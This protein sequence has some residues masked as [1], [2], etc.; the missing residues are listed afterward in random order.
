MT[1]P[2]RVLAAGAAAP[3]LRLPA[4]EVSGAWGGGGK[5]QS[6]V[7]GPDEDALTLAWTAATSAIANAGLEPSKVG[8]L[9]WGTTRPPFA[10]GPSLALLQ[11]ALRLP[12]TAAGALLT[13]SPAAGMD[14]LLA[15]WD[16]VAAGSVDTA[17]VVV[18]DAIVPGL[19]TP[20]ER[21]A[22]AGAVALV[23]ARDGGTA[24]LTDRVLRTWPVLDRYRG[25]GEAETRDLY[26]PRLFR[27]EV[28]LPL[29][30][31]VG[32]AV[33]DDVRAWSL[34]D[35]DGRL[36]AAVARKL[37]ADASSSAAAYADLGDTGAAAALLGLLGALD[38]PGRVAVV[39]FG[40]GR[41]VAVTL[42]ADG[43]VP[44][45]GPRAL[46]DLGT[47]RL[48]SY[49]EVLRARG[50]LVPSG[51][52]VPMGVPPGG[53][54][55]VRGNVELLGLHGAQCSECGTVNVP[56][57]VHPTCINCGNAKFEVAELPST[58]TVHTFV[59]NHTMPAPF[60]APLPLVVVD[61][62][63]G[64]RIQLQGMPED[65]ATLAIG[66]RVDLHL[67]RYAVERGVPVYGFK[68]RRLGKGAS[69]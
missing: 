26:D 33:G 65:A 58:G 18:A 61:L 39:G 2:V 60:V 5:G 53:A 46:A 13:G 15:A 67:R 3:S 25:E 20:F 47:G 22:G 44:G 35:P 9:W 29:L 27:E 52:G 21:R 69:T 11:T 59:V 54:G 6:A 16:A 66:D 1:P 55:F 28:F 43:P 45:A 41:A 34:P 64:T 38:Q 48:A 50:Q 32:G 10:E 63:D 12:A 30:A 37:G 23:L 24:S 40:G 49:A 19:G 4:S 31:Q 36:G 8:G 42:D 62:D 51:E 57:S 7:C 68:V 17:L 14:A 56:P